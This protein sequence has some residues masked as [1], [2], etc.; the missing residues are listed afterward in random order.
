MYRPPGYYEL[1]KAEQLIRA[2]TDVMTDPQRDP[3]IEAAFERISKQAWKFFKWS[4]AEVM[5]FSS[6]P[7]DAKFGRSLGHI[8]M[9]LMNDN[10][11]LAYTIPTLTY[12]Y[13]P[14]VTIDEAA[15]LML[16]EYLPVV[17]LPPSNTLMTLNTLK[18]FL[19]IYM[20]HLGKLLGY[21]KVIVM[22]FRRYYNHIMWLIEQKAPLSQEQK[23]FFLNVSLFM[24]N[25]VSQYIDA[26]W[27]SAPME[28]NIPSVFEQFGKLWT[29]VQSGPFTKFITLISNRNLES[30]LAY[31]GPYVSSLPIVAGH[32]LPLGP[33]HEIDMQRIDSIT[34]QHAEQLQ[35]SA[36]ANPTMSIYEGIESGPDANQRIE[37]PTFSQMIDTLTDKGLDWP[38]IPDIPE[39]NLVEYKDAWY[40]EYFS[41]W[42]DRPMRLKETGEIVTDRALS[43]EVAGD[44]AYARLSI[45]E[46]RIADCSELLTGSHTDRKVDY[47]TGMTAWFMKGETGQSLANIQSEELDMRSFFIKSAD[48][49]IRPALVETIRPIREMLD[50]DAMDGVSYMRMSIGLNEYDYKR[51]R[52]ALTAC[53]NFYKL[54]TLYGTVPQIAAPGETDDAA[55]ERIC[56]FYLRG[57]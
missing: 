20:M 34:W 8:M 36:E 19:R 15:T 41:K 13:L 50:A 26:P 18:S 16:S 37:S 44:T 29:H 38:F 23:T 48:T 11:R 14:Y 40:Y 9:H 5:Q 39:V 21:R 57:Y 28:C 53:F 1:S 42:R 17:K 54:K 3:K 25:K 31:F 56:R 10:D 12:R 32:F 7:D 35:G 47:S 43:Q 4:M 24:H 52:R 27:D 49:M 45:D 6:D 46:W 55:L 30:L 2:I 22:N 33:Y 51:S